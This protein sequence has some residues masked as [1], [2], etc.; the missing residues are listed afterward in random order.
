MA[1]RKTPQDLVAIF[2][3]SFH[4]T[5]GNIID[6]SLKSSEDVDFDGL[7]FS[8]L[9]SGLHLVEEDVIYFSKD[10][11]QG[12]CIFRRRKTTEEGHRGFR[13]SSLGILLQKSAR[14]RPWVHTPA[15]KYLTT[16]IYSKLEAANVLEPS[17]SDWEPAREFFE[18]RRA[19]SS[20][21]TTWH[22]W[23]AELDDV[24]HDASDPPAFHLPHL[25]RVLG[26]SSLPLYKHVL[27]RRRILI[28]TAPPVEAACILCHVAGDLCLEAQLTP[29]MG[30]ASAPVEVLGIVTLAGLDRLA[31]PSMRGWVACTTDALLRD[32]P[33]CYDLLVD[34]TA[35]PIMYAPRL[36]STPSIQTSSSRS[37]VRFSWSDLR[38]WGEVERLLRRDPSMPTPCACAP[39]TS[40]KS[41]LAFS[42]FGRVYEDMCV[43]CASLWMQAWRGSSPTNDGQ[44]GAIHLEGEDE[45]Y[46]GPSSG[47]SHVRT[48]GLG[49]EGT[50]AARKTSNGSSTMA[51][52]AGKGKARQSDPAPGD[53][54]LSLEEDHIRR[55]EAQLRLTL[56]LLQT[57]HAHTLFQLSV[58]QD[59]L[60]ENNES[61]PLILLPKDMISFEL[62]PWSASDARYLGWLC[63]EYGGTQ[64]VTV[65]RT[66]RD[67]LNFIFGYR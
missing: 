14:P 17:P 31:A 43:V 21:S 13:L 4:P 55:R 36:L 15:L 24:L 51:K 58:L 23:A 54:G 11:H 64:K 3:A 29:D 28:Y 7:E 18:A 19:Q 59:F 42:D 26:P 1:D 9:P 41:A 32:K 60:K 12:V 25:L 30:R 34:L 40:E 45:L 37:T 65:R 5:R 63:D 50:P 62:G 66:W 49:I 6:W 39:N 67:T 8:A 20:S 48:L 35:R 38:V 53:T 47:T 52:L 27:C 44:W 10:G 2:H 57:F 56:A 22:S 33:A 46:V 61:S 16:Q